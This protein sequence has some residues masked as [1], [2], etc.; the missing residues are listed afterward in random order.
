MKGKKKII[1]LVAAIA[2]TMSISMP[3]YNVYA[4]Q[5]QAVNE[6]TLSTVDISYV[7]P[8]DDFYEAVNGQWKND[9]INKISEG[10]NEKSTYS[11]IKENNEKIMRNEFD[12]F[13]LNKNKYGINSDERKMA[14]VYLNYLNIDERNS[15]GIKPIEKYLSEIDKVNSIAD[16][17]NLLSDEEI[18]L[19]TDL[20]DFKIQDNNELNVHELYIDTTELSLL[21]SDK[22]KRENKDAGYESK[23]INFYSGLLQ[24]SGF[25][26][27]ESQKM[28]NDLFTFEKNVAPCILGDSVDENNIDKSKCDILVKIDELNG[29]APNIDL[30][31]IMKSLK[32]DNA[33]Y[34][35]V[36]QMDWLKKLN[37]LWT[38]D[39]LPLIKN[40]LK[41]NVIKSS[42]RYLSDEMDKLYYD[43]IEDILGV[44]FQYTSIED[45]AYIKIESLFPSSLGKLYSEK[46]LS[47]EEQNDVQ[48]IADEIM[49]QYKKKINNCEWISDATRKNLIEKLS[50]VK[51]NIGFSRSN[52]DYS[53]ADIKLYSQ[54]GT[55]LENVVNLAKAANSNQLKII[56]DK[57]GKDAAI[58]EI[59]PQDV[60]AEYHLLT[61]NIIITS[62]IIQPGLYSK[63]S[64]REKNLAGI[65]IVIAH[66]ISHSLDMLGVFFNGDGDFENMWT[67]DDFNEY[68]SK[69]SYISDYYSAIEGLPGK[70]IDGKATLCENIADIGAMSCILDLM[71]NT[72]NS[73]YKMFFEEYAKAYK[74]VKTKEGY[75]EALE[76]DEHCP[77]KIRVNIVLAQFQKFYDTYGI[78][79]DDRMYVNPEFRI[80]PL[81]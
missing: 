62:G 23:V 41:I 73:D 7:R 81:W 16:L 32:L 74:C 36:S 66:E 10:Y 45:E 4:E 59:L 27:T 22:Y 64:P 69:V 60:L 52:Q 9:A 68:K 18:D 37:E 50:K 49:A 61:N 54:G 39:N 72:E 8:Q 38:K 19:L 5:R 67:E 47:K 53:N 6:E 75:E 42:G 78:D 35:K 65:G 51:I 57:I 31:R 14:D 34:I 13:L 2:V 44:K 80:K 20:I 46:A 33:N 15:Q 56:N 58:S 40:Y 28:M 1:S 48:N 24:K 30:P 26:E 3:T 77:D 17:N 29:I 21:D 70:F 79:E 76:N 12:G 55:L 25:S 43:F 11:D 71:A 63:D